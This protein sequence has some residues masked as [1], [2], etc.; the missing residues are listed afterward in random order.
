M[1]EDRKK[2]DAIIGLATVGS[3]VVGVVSLTAA[4]LALAS[5]EYLGVGACLVA[6]ALALGLLANAVLRA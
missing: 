2:L 6:A 5:G 4:V 1:G 3:G